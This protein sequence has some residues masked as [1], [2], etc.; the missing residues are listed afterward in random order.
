M[1]L[2]HRICR[3]NVVPAL[4]VKAGGP[5]KIL[6]C[7]AKHPSRLRQAP[8]SEVMIYLLDAGPLVSALA[9]A[10]ACPLP[11]CDVDRLCQKGLRF[12]KPAL[13]VRRR[14]VSAKILVTRPILV[15]EKQGR[16]VTRL[17]HIVIDAALLRTGWRQQLEKLLSDGVLQAWLGLDSRDHCDDLICHFSSSRLLKNSFET[18]NTLQG[19]SMEPSKKTRLQTCQMSNVCCGLCNVVVKIA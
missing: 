6:G 18:A 17:M 5:S 7:I 9:F 19:R 4:G 8:Q 12:F 11:T 14:Q 16:V 13:D 15:K 1:H 3:N 2:E 10:S